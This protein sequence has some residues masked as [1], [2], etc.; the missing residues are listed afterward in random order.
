MIFSLA[1]TLVVTA[2]TVESVFRAGK[3]RKREESNRSNIVGDLG[4][5]YRR[6]RR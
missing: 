5:E 4:R 1:S 3:A 2:E 6:G